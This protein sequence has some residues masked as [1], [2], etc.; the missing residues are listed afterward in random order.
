M[1][2]IKFWGKMVINDL[3][4]K[5]DNHLVRSHECYETSKNDFE[6]DSYGQGSMVD[7]SQETVYDEA[8]QND[9]DSTWIQEGLNEE[10]EE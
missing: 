9:Y 10:G 8:M 6:V 4:F 7:E 3:F 2:G 5:I 1:R